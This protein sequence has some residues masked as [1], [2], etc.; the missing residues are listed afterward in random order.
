MPD[1]TLV[2]LRGHRR[3]CPECGSL[4]IAEQAERG[5]TICIECGRVIEDNRITTLP[6]RAYTREEREEKTRVGSPVT[7]TRG[8][9]GLST[10]IGRSDDL[11]E[12]SGKQRQKYRRLR[13]LHRQMTQVQ[14][15]TL[16]FA[17]TELR[18]FASVLELPSATHEEVARLYEK[19][20]DQGVVQGRRIED[21]LG[22][23][24]YLVSRNQGN[25][26]TMDEITDVTG[27]NGDELGQTYR[28]VARELD[29]RILPARPE[30]YLPRFASDLGVSGEIQAQ[31]RKIIAAARDYDL[32]TGKG[33]TGITAVALYLAMQ[34]SCEQPVQEDI[35][36]RLGVAQTTIRNHVATFQQEL[37][38]G[39]T[40]TS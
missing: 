22:A 33:P 1:Q 10:T 25:P 28:Y 14:R 9:R 11:Y 32:L 20:M 16:Q 23:L 36:D 38:I 7:F 30:D 24:I 27:S 3:F 37:D 21:I 29:L 34:E 31:A 39:K 40:G 5:E 18:Q 26:R 17:L 4:K 8:G 15:G 13:R 2:T 6:A 19:A 12:L 35:A